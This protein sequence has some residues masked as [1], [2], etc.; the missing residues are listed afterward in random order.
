MQEELQPL[1]D[2]IRSE[3]LDKANAEA[4]RIVAAAHEEAEKV[5]TAAKAEADRIKDEAKAEADKLGAR[6]G[7]SL[8]QAARDVLLKLQG[9]IQKTF[10][11]MLR[12]ETASAM[13]DKA[14]LA[15]CI[16]A[17]ATSPGAEIRVSEQD[18]DALAKSLVS[19]AASQA[20]SEGGLHV[21]AADGVSA[22]FH[23]FLAGGRVE[24]DFSADAVSEALA[25]AIRPALA[26]IVFPD[27]T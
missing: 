15:K 27:R 2:K 22:G 16:E 23:V 12:T 6:A 4:A 11:N 10:E 18:A 17:V 7:E 21:V 13:T 25:G 26:K 9:D 3:G 14:L 8:R 5:V 20:G 19:L 1:L 24:H